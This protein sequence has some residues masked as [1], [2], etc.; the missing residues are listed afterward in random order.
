VKE[1]KLVRS[2]AVS[3]WW[4]LIAWP[5][6]FL[7]YFLTEALIPVRRCTPIHCKLDDLIPFCEF[8]VIPY[9]FWYFLIAGSLLYFARHHVK[10]FRK[11]MTFFIVTMICANIIFVLFPSR[12]DLRPAII[13]RDNVFSKIVGFLYTFDTNTNVFPSLHVA[14]SIGIAYVWLSEKTF[15]L[16]IRLFV[17]IS[18]ILIC[19]S[20]AFIKQHSVL[21]GIAAI[22]ISVAA[23]FFSSLQ[24][25]FAG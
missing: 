9:V 5:L 1:R 25:K 14:F 8:F 12:Q 11:L 17:L 23:G 13:P 3:H 18:S 4:L 10:S 6:Y 16:P 19:F 15:P 2:P 21:D 24:L 7:S 22:P 20:T